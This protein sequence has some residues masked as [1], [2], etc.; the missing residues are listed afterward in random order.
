MAGF[1]L[2]DIQ[3]ALQTKDRPD[4]KKKLP[5]Q[6]HQHLPVFDYNSADT[7]P[8]H[9]DF[10]HKIELQPCTTPPHGTLY[11]MSVNEL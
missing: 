2:E 9:R 10:D 11:N 6:Y 7:L 1:L 4:P 8:P 5:L 3:V